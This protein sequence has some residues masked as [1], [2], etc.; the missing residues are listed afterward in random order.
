MSDTRIPVPGEIWTLKQWGDAV[1]ID[2]A[3]V[4]G[5]LFFGSDA[6]MCACKLATFHD[7]YSPPSRPIPPAPA[8]RDVMYFAYKNGVCWRQSWEPNGFVGSAPDGVLRVPLGWGDA[9]W[10]TR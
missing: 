8:D 7:Y 6:E 3:T 2:A 10:V 4:Q 5:V 9:E 1:T